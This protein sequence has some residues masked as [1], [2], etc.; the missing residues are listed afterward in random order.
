MCLKESALQPSSAFRHVTELGKLLLDRHEQQDAESEDT[1]TDGKTVC[2]RLLECSINI[3]PCL[4]LRTDGGGDYNVDIY[5][6]QLS[7]ISLFLAADLDLLVAVRT[8]PD[9]P[10]LPERL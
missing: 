9:Q 3:P 5:Q 2:T 6:V 4:I 7:L 8:A 1:K 10:F